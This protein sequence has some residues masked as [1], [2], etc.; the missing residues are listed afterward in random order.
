MSSKRGIWMLVYPNCFV[1][2][3]WW[4]QTDVNLSFVSLTVMLLHQA[5]GSYSRHMFPGSLSILFNC[6]FILVCLAMG[7][8]WMTSW[9][10]FTVGS[11]SKV[12]GLPSCLGPVRTSWNWA[13]THFI[14]R[15]WGLVGPAVLGRVPFETRDDDAGSGC[16]GK[17]LGWVLPAFRWTLTFSGRSGDETKWTTFAQILSNPRWTQSEPDKTGGFPG[18]KIS[19]N[20]EREEVIICCSLGQ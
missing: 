16:L 17:S 19:Q 15:V 8:Q 3:A 14:V 1:D 10:A 12:T 4:I 2:S 20:M 6:C 13:R 7:W 5:K 18:I 11:M 9:T